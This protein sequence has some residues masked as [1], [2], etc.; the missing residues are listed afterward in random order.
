MLVQSQIY[1]IRGINKW[2]QSFA[3]RNFDLEDMELES[4]NSG[5][6]AKLPI[7]KLGEYEIWVI[8]IK[9][10]KLANFLLRL[11]TTCIT[12]PGPELNYTLMEKLVLSLVF[13]A[14]RLRRSRTSVVETPQ[15]PWTLFTNES[16][17][18]DGSG[19]GL[20]LTS[21]KGTE[22]IYALRFQFTASN[23]AAEYEALIAGLRI[24]AQ[25]GVRNVHVSVD[26]KLVASQ[27]LGAYVAKE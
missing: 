9:Q 3:L 13:T 7:L 26:S 21:P 1:K 18:V 19:A 17:C 12:T 10:F 16:S 4:T 8:R 20:I 22:F 5:P 15:E 14:N 11:W 2:Y 24:T 27:V 6:T 25:I 23:N